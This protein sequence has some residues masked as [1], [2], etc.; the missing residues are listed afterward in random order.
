MSW[1]TKTPTSHNPFP[2]VSVCFLGGGGL[3]CFGF[4]GPS[5]GFS[6]VNRHLRALVILGCCCCCSS[7]SSSSSSSSFPS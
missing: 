4:E 5:G 1:G 3:G 2:S 7:S 6:P